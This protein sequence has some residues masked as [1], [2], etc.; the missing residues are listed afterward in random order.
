MRA[1]A[2]DLY[3]ATQNHLA[4]CPKIVNIMRTG[5][6][7]LLGVLFGVNNERYNLIYDTD[8]ELTIYGRAHT[9]CTS[10]PIVFNWNREILN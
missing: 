4:Q 7:S 8:C 9:Q 10:R 2:H 3:S 5:R 1:F 6:Q